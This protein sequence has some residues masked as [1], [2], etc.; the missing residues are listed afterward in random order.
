MLSALEFLLNTC[1]HCTPV[2]L[3]GLETRHT[4]LSQGHTH[5]AQT[6]KSGMPFDVVLCCPGYTGH[7]K[8]KMYSAYTF[9]VDSPLRGSHNNV[10]IPSVRTR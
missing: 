5:T 10:V 2:G 9:E 3:L 4:E 1:T 6:F 8:D 7:S